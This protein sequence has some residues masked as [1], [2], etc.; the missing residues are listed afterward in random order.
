MIMRCV[1]E[2]LTSQNTKRI[3]VVDD[4]R[5]VTLTLKARLKAVGLF[6]VD[7]D[8]ELALKHFKLVRVQ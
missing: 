3:L 2:A 6:G 5:D 8:P 7:T 1:Q 4:E